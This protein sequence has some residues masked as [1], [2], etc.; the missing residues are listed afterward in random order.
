MKEKN[1]DFKD[2]REKMKKQIGNDELPQLELLLNAEDSLIP[3]LVKKQDIK[4]LEHLAQTCNLYANIIDTII[5]AY[6]EGPAKFNKTG[7]ASDNVFKDNNDFE[8]LL[9]I[10]NSCYFNIGLIH[11]EKGNRKDALLYF[12]D[13]F[14]LSEKNTHNWHKDHTLYKAE[15]EIKSILGSKSGTLNEN[16][17]KKIKPT[18]NRKVRIMNF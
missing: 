2:L 15:I 9:K 18:K 12:Y 13:A 7:P 6:K 16:E 1:I 14:R 8:G 11:K 4:E 17:P 10:R 3:S 5:D